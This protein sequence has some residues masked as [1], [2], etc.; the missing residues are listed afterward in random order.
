[1]TFPHQAKDAVVSTPQTDK[2]VAT[3]HN[4]QN[5]DDAL[6]QKAV[7]QSGWLLLFIFQCL[8]YL[9]QTMIV[10]IVVYL[11]QAMVYC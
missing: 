5:N 3:P 2:K 9:Q 8:L 6:Q 1:V 11:Q 10:F 7:S 4:V